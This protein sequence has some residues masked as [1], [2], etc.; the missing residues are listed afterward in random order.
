MI[1]H[2]KSIS[3]TEQSSSKRLLNH[4]P[5]VIFAGRWEYNVFIAFQAYGMAF[6]LRP[7]ALILEVLIVFVLLSDPIRSL[8]RRR[9]KA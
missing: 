1:A 4:E 6:M 3:R 5:Y 9:K 2:G 7:V 8:V